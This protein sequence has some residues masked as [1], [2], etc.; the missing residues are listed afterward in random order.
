MSYTHPEPGFFHLLLW[1]RSIYLSVA[2]QRIAMSHKRSS[3]KQSPVPY[4]GF[5]VTHQTSPQKVRKEAASKHS[6]SAPLEFGQER[7]K[8]STQPQDVRI[9]LFNL[10]QLQQYHS[11]PFPSQILSKTLTVLQANNSEWC[12]VNQYRHFQD[13][14]VKPLKSE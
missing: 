4:A 5:Y 9:F 13:T 1:R 14:T 7:K 2:I 8:E 3:P 12:K 11:Q 6:W 10:K